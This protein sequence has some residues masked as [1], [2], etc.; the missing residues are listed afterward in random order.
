MASPLYNRDILRLAASVTHYGRLDNPEATADRRSLTCGSRVIA[1]VIL[2]AEER[3]A[4]LGLDVS[5]CALGQA[6]AALLSAHV[7]GRSPAEM[8]QTTQKLR[9]LLS[10]EEQAVDT[11]FW[12]GISVLAA[13]RD[14]PARHPSILLPFE[15]V[16]AAMLEA[17]HRRSIWK[18]DGKATDD[19][20]TIV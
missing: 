8:Q 12:P 18:T 6:S 9:Q 20:G 19:S 13:A 1:D 16:S 7:I 2:D 14:Y 4:G 17:L 11:D 15:V 10:A 5:A 3:L